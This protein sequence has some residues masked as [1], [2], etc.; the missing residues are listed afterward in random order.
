MGAIISDAIARVER[1]E[2]G[3]QAWTAQRRAPGPERECWD[4]S[5]TDPGI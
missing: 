5:S 2:L 4:E 3:R 1:P